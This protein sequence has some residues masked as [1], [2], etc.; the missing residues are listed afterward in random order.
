MSGTV[1]F[2]TPPSY[3]SVFPNAPS[4]SFLP[5]PSSG[6]FGDTA[7]TEITGNGATITKKPLDMLRDA[8]EWKLAPTAGST[9]RELLQNH[10]LGEQDREIIKLAQTCFYNFRFMTEKGREEYIKQEAKGLKVA[11]TKG[12]LAEEELSDYREHLAT[13]GSRVSYLESNHQTVGQDLTELNGRLKKLSELIE[14]AQ[15]KI[16]KFESSYKELEDWKE[17]FPDSD[18]QVRNAQ[19][20]QKLLEV[21]ELEPQNENQRGRQKALEQN[22]LELKNRKQPIGVIDRLTNHIRFLWHYN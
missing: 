18:Y 9:F 15:E 19:I 3:P 16:T 13:L 7:A 14:S 20:E 1:K 5:P 6:C 8:I 12:N 10:E 2:D 21:S 4:D 17:G 11:I 22:L